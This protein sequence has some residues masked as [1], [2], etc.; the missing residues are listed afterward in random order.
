MTSD[1]QQAKPPVSAV[2]AGPLRSSIASDLG[3][4]ADRGVGG[5]SRIRRG[6]ASSCRAGIFSPGLAMADR[7]GRGGHWPPR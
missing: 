1:L 3:D 4:R 6:L 2:L 5:E 7:V